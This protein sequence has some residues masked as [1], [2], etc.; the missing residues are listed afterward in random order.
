MDGSDDWV[1]EKEYVTSVEC[2]SDTMLV[3]IESK[4]A[5]DKEFVNE[6]SMPVVK[7]V[8]IVESISF[9]LLKKTLSDIVELKIEEK[10]SEV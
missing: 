5:V 2:F 3:S 10:R 9:S 4:F 6:G 1:G 7:S 8:K